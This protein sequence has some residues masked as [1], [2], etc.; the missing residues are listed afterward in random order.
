MPM[1]GWMDR[2]TNEL[3][4]LLAVTRVQYTGEMVKVFKN[5]KTGKII[6][7]KEPYEL[8]NI[9]GELLPRF[10]RWGIASPGNDDGF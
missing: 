6:V 2:R 7:V 5:Q 4:D 9:D 8:L 1:L 3:Y 10:C